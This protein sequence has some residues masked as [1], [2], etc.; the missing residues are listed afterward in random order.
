MRRF[1]GKIAIITG[2]TSGIGRSTAKLLAQEGA[3]VV[4]VGRSEERG[5][6]VVSNIEKEGGIA[7]FLF[8]DVS[9][10]ESIISLKERFVMQF[11]RLDILFNNAGIWITEPLE[12][13]TEELLNKVISTN[14]SST[15]FM[16]K[17]FVDLLETSKGTIVNNASMG[18]LENYTN[19]NKQYMYCSA[20]AG[21]IK[22]SKLAAKDMAPEVRV[23][24]I[25]PGTIDTELFTNRDFSRFI[26]RIPLGRMG[27][28]EEVA[29]LVSFLA[30][31]DASFITGAVISIDGGMSLT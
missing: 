22:I 9:K 2:A 21:V 15:L 10:E 23:N 13:I 26:S 6:A 4:V 29:K 25:C 7:S 12:S 28:P 27:K 3:T 8:C 11:S 14:M 18:G 5:A 17:H 19:G 31:D 30:S 1:D 16:M 20:K 24:C